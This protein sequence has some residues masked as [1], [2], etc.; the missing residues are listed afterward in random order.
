MGVRCFAALF[1]LLILSA[2]SIGQSRIG[3]RDSFFVAAELKAPANGSTPSSATDTFDRANSDPMSTSMSDGV[4]VWTSGPGA[5]TD[6]KI[7][8]NQSTASSG[9]AGAIVSTPASWSANHYSQIVVGATIPGCGVYV[10]MQ[11]TTSG[12]GYLL[13]VASITKL[14][15]FK[16]TDTGTMGFTQLGAD[17]TVS[18]IVNGDTIKFSA[19]GTT[20]EAFINGASQGTRTDSTYSTGSPGIFSQD[21]GA[22]T[23]LINS[24]TAADL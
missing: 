10:R 18:T 24:F 5:L 8:S 11:S 13:Y 20:L 4:S 6:M 9:S 16:A 1:T 3:L 21:G 15:I 17:I 2:S 7:L 23:G 12:S 22:G 14:Q 19:S